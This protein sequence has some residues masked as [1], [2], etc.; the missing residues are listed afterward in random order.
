M[1]VYEQYYKESIQALTKY[2]EE[3][4][5][6]PTEKTWNKMAVS[7]NYLTSQSLGYLS[8]LRFPDLC[9]K[10]YREI[11]KRRRGI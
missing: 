2:I 7:K 1:S 5:A 6:M 11:Q 10:K 9:K 4:K 8:G 3:N